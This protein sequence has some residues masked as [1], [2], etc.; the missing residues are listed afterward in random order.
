LHEKYSE[1]EVQQC[2]EPF[3][4]LTKITALWNKTMDGLA[5]FSGGDFFKIIFLQMPVEALVIVAE[6]FIPNPEA[7]FTIGRPLPYT[8]FKS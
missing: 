8:K 6:G 1:A 5:I 7:I 4:L 2:I 3:D